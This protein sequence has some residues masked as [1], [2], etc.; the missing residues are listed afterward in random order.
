MPGKRENVHPRAD[1]TVS[2]DSAGVDELGV[3]PWPVLLRRRLARK[4]GLDPRWAVLWVV[5]AGLF[6]VSFTITILVVSLPRIATDLNSSTSTLNW[7]ITGPMLAFGVVGPAFGKAGD[8]WGHKRVFVIG[9]LF[10]GVFAASAE[11]P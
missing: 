7:S 10:A 4:V 2:F 9:L 5:L 3:I 8:L 1:Q 11:S 6:T